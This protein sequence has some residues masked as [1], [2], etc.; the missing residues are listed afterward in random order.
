MWLQFFLI[1][2]LSCHFNIL[3]I[4]PIWYCDKMPESWNSGVKQEVSLSLSLCYD[5][6]LVGQSV[7]E[8]STHLG[9][10]TRYLLVFDNYDPVLW[11]T[12]SVERMGLSFVCDAG[13]RQHS[14]SWV[15]VP[16]NLWPYFT[17]SDL[18][19]PF[20]LRHTTSRV[21]MEV[22]DPASTWVKKCHFLGNKFLKALHNN[23]SL[24]LIKRD[25]HVFS[26]Q[27]VVIA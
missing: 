9:R 14:L 11:G 6:Q 27:R 22:F 10:M 15:R 13:T 16:L 26:S 8:W 25:K 19:L 5:W 20:S 23:Q 1:L 3:P 2:L 12:L 21:T 18:R 24:L 7:L 4:N 17:V